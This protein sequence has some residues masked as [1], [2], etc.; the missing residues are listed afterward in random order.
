MPTTISD[1]RK[2]FDSIASIG[3]D[4]KA[5]EGPTELMK[6]AV[7]IGKSDLSADEKEF[8]FESLRSECLADDGK[9]T[10]DEF[11]TLLDKIEKMRK[12]KS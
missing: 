5:I 9:V 6:L 11:N 3:G 2:I 12:G 4:K 1:L 7:E 8:F 10:K